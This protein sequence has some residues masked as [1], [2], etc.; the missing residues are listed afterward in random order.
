[1]ELKEIIGLAGVPLIIALVEMSKGQVTH[2]KDWPLVAVFWGLVL[3]VGAALAM[4]TEVAQ[5]I[6]YGLV[7]GLAASGLYDS[8][9]QLPSAE[10]TGG[11]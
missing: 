7:A 6:V 11:D 10:Q 8:R 9:K 2:K 3:N 1:V 5:G 4:G